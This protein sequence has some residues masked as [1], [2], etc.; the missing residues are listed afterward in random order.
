MTAAGTKGRPVEQAARRLNNTLCALAA[1]L[2]IGGFFIAVGGFQSEAPGGYWLLFLGLV[3]MASG[4][5]L[6]TLGGLV[7]ALAAPRG[8]GRE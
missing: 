8:D 5:V 6:A 7:R 2:V 3:S 4:L 1:V